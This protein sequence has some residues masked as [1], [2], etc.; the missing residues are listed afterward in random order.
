M[1]TNRLIFSKQTYSIL[2]TAT[3]EYHDGRSS[4]YDSLYVWT[5]HINIEN[6]GDTVAQLINRHWKIVDANGQVREVQG[7][8]VVGIQPFI[9]PGEKFNYSSETSLQTPSGIMFGSYEMATKSGDKFFIDIPAFSLDCPH[10]K[11]QMN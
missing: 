4:P 6:R 5:Y 1:D 2:V 10:F 7:I 11:E 9:A 3:P 8:G